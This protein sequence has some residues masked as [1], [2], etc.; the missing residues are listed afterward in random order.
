MKAHSTAF[1]EKIKEL[2]R[3]LDSII[4]YGDTVLGNTQ[5]NAVT[6]SFKGGILKSVMKQLEIDS[7]VEIPIGTDLNYKFGVKVNGQYE[8]IDFG[9]YIVKEIEKQ[10]DT[11]SYKII[12]YDKMLYS[13]IDYRS[14]GVEFPISIRDYIN[15]ICQQLGLTFSNINDEFANYDKQIPNELYLDQNGNSLGYT[16]RDVLDELSQVTA[17]TI[18]INQNDE[19]E[20]RYTRETND[21]IDES[22]LKDVNVNFGEK[23]G[24]INSI[25][26]SRSAESDNV[27]LQD[28]E[29]VAN[30]GLCELKI[31]D[32][33]IMNFNDR[34]DYLPDILEKL[35]GLE[36]YLNDFSST[37]ITYFELCDKYNVKIGD[38]IYSCLMLNDEIDITQGL[39]EFIYTEMPRES[40]TDYTKADKDDRKINQ[41]YIIAN[42]VSQEIQI[43]TS[44]IDSQNEEI[45]RT[46]QTVK[47]LEISVSQQQ[48]QINNTTGE[49]ER[50]DDTLK[51]MI[52]NFGTDALNISRTDSPNSAQINNEGMKLY[53]Y[54][55][56][57]LISN[58]NGTGIQKLIVVGDAQIGY[59]RFVKEKDEKNHECTDIH[60]LVSNIQT[61][62]D[63]EVEN[64]GN[65]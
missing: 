13:M 35:N 58:Q 2:G 48:T 52:Y 19:L 36:Y 3:E 43:V 64:N 45:T 27:Y 54:D 61:L 41:T 29:S 25:V 20:I 32:N 33:Q 12:C 8:Y 10:E 30:D 53:N 56:L 62:E 9:N 44:R 4:T 31:I 18:C 34:S 14:V 17:S 65:V 22:Y 46:A 7:N 16:F 6:P 21:I 23:Y 38:K 42:K 26:L 28:E 63:L 5:L 60:H 50:I 40:I 24:K 37:G 59:L 47:G 39:E 1:K 49:I 57:K 11:L 55:N 15:A 51:D